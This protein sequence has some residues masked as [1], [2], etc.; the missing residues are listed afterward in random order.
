MEKRKRVGQRQKK[1]VEKTGEPLGEKMLGN[2]FGKKKNEKAFPKAGGAR[3]ST[4]KEG[5]HQR[6]NLQ[7]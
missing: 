5:R 2:F 4:I 7:L 6:R 1:F 3:T